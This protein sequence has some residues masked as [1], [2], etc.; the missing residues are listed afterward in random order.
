LAPPDPQYKDKDGS[1][2]DFGQG[3]EDAG[4]ARPFYRRARFWVVAVPVVF[5]VAMVRRNPRNHH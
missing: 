1:S 5:M 2:S 3:D 4:P